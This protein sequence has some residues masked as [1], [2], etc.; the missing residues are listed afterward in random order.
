MP[1]DSEGTDG[2]EGRGENPYGGDWQFGVGGDSSHTAI[3]F[4]SGHWTTSVGTEVG[5]WSHRLSQAIHSITP[6]HLLLIGQKAPV[7]AVLRRWINRWV[8]AGGPA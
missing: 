4:R 8:L 1:V 2:R 3:I 5:R 6:V 7:N